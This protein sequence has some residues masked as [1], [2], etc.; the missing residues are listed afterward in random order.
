MHFVLVK[1]DVTFTNMKRCL[2]AQIP[3]PDSS[4]SRTTCQLFARRT[5]AS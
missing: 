1:I 4:V 5:E 3:E 2:S